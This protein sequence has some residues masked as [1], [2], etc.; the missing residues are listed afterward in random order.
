[1]FFKIKMLNFNSRLNLRKKLA[2]K[3]P[4]GFTSVTVSNIQ[5]VKNLTGKKIN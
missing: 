5:K 3:R 1:M 4:V 2:L